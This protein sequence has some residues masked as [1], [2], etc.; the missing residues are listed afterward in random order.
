MQNEKFV[1][2]LRSNV[3]VKTAYE[4]LHKDDIIS[5]AM[6]YT[7]QTVK[8]NIAKSMAANGARPNENGIGSQSAAVVKSDV[9]K[10]NYKDI[11]EVIRRVARGDKISFS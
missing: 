6:Q 2:L 8:S 10:L 4:V 11:D 3:D 7:A 5:G 1:D 9:T